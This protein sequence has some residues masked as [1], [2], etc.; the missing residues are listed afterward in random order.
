[1]KV[2]LPKYVTQIQRPGGSVDMYFRRGHGPYT[3]LPSDINSVEFAEIYDRLMQNGSPTEPRHVLTARYQKQLESLI[4]SKIKQARL[5]DTKRG[6]TIEISQEWAI[7]QIQK[8]AYRCAVTGL[9]FATPNPN[10]TTRLNP[11]TPS[12]D[13]ID[14]AKGYTPENVRIVI[15]AFNLM[16]LDWPEAVLQ[17]VAKAYKP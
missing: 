13:R 17:S 12:L 7:S 11:F 10:R 6:K 9:P 14:N 1:M 16:R 15:A 4:A 3:R 2:K 8:Q 5:R